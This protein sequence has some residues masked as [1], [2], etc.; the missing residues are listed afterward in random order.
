MPFPRTCRFRTLRSSFRLL[1]RL[2][3]SCIVHLAIPFISDSLPAHVPHTHE[4]GPVKST[5][6]SCSLDLGLDRCN[7]LL[8]PFVA[9]ELSSQPTMDMDWTRVPV[10]T[11][12]P[13]LLRVG[14]PA[15][16]RGPTISELAFQ[17]SDPQ[18]QHLI[19]SGQRRG[20]GLIEG[21]FVSACSA[22]ETGMDVRDFC[23]WGTRRVEGRVGGIVVVVLILL[24]E[25]RG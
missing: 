6:H 16:R 1:Q 21:G 12:P 8:G 10:P 5:V 17:L 3:S 24:V 18:P 15:P 19:L 9:A 23:G 13:P 2:F 4:L 25:E 22:R 7:S 20:L 11:A 14:I